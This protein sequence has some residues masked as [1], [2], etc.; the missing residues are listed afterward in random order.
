M[1]THWMPYDES[2]DKIRYEE[3]TSLTIETK[4]LITLA[5]TQ[6]ER[7]VPVALDPVE[8]QAREYL[9]ET[10]VQ[11]S[12]RIASS[13]M[14]L[15]VLS[16]QLQQD[17]PAF[18][19]RAMQLFTDNNQYLLESSSES[20]QSF[21]FEQKEFVDQA[22]A[23]YLRQFMPTQQVLAKQDVTTINNHCKAKTAV[24]PSPADVTPDYLEWMIF[25]DTS[26]ALDFDSQS[27][28]E[29]SGTTSEC[30]STLAGFN[31][32]YGDHPAPFIAR[33]RI[34]FDHSLNPHTPVSPSELKD[35][36]RKKASSIYRGKKVLTIKT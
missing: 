23:I 30:D 32:E 33:K 24:Q 18:V 28:Y 31:E 27:D 5:E 21:C 3:D 17:L 11:L 29:M 19:A 6:Q 34:C 2:A 7:P 16:L 15:Q 1:H 8:V 13:Q 12:Q 22:V 10:I 36:R 4:N 20:S 35:Q 14:Q 26:D 25:S 9:A